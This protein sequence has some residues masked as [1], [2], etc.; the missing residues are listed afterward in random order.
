MKNFFLLSLL[1]FTSVCLA[2]RE[3]YNWLWGG[4]SGKGYNAYIQMTFEGDRRAFLTDSID[5]KTTTSQNNASI[6]D[7]DNGRLLFYTNGC[8]VTNS[9]HQIMDGGDSI[10]FGWGY[11]LVADCKSGYSWSQNTFI[12]DDPDQEKGYYI[13]HK[14]VEKSPQGSLSS[15]RFPTVWYSYVDMNA[16]NG[17]GRVVYKNKELFRT[18]R[19]SSGFNHVVRHDN[20][21]DWWFI[22]MEDTTNVFYIFGIDDQGP[23]IHDTLRLGPK[24]PWDVSSAGQAKFSPDGNQWAMPLKFHGIDIYDFDKEAGL[25][26]NRR[27]YAI[28]N[29]NSQTG[30][31]WSANGRFIYYSHRD[32]LYQIDTDEL[33]LHLA[34]S[35]IAVWDSTSNPFPTRF[36]YMARGPDCRIYMSSYSSTK[37]IHVINNPDAKGLD[38]DFRQHAID[39]LGVSTGTVSIPN[40]PNFRQEIGPPC[41]PDIT[42]NTSYFSLPE[43]QNFSPYPNP[44]SEQ[45]FLNLPSRI[46]E[47]TL[48]IFDTNGNM[49][50]NYYSTD[51][52][53]VNVHHFRSGAYILRVLSPDGQAYMSRFIKI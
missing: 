3:D 53:F 12:V 32:S 23:F 31:E 37:T 33:D 16:N 5:V 35:L 2:Q 9:D 7:P 1:C 38:C 4:N 39:L 51:L 40:F 48:S 50:L 29:L 13:I 41:Y 52:S 36:G 49:V 18:T 26:S 11:N 6:S 17:K 28:P 25:L 44:T 22:Q 34:Q 24:R 30:L 27:N 43:I 10:N 19:T 21:E 42:T 15:I 20:G 47:G 14:P 46:T 8:V 45:L